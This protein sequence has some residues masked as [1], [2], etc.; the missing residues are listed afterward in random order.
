MAAIREGVPAADAL[1]RFARKNLAALAADLDRAGREGQAAVHD[2]RKRLKLLRSLLRLLRPALGDA[3]FRQ[4]DAALRRAHH[5]LAAAR[6]AGA[7][8]E[9]VHKL[10]AYARKRK[11][12]VDLSGL[13]A[14]VGAAAAGAVTEGDL[15]PSIAEAREATASLAARSDAW[16]LPRR[17]VSLFVEGMRDCYAKARRNLEKGFRGEDIE[18]LHEARKAVIHLRHHLDL[19]APLWPAMLKPWSKELQALR[20]LLG[21]ACDLDE[22]EEFARAS[23]G[24]GE[25][26]IDLIGMRRRDLLL[27]AEH[28]AGRLFAESPSAFAGRLSAIWTT[29]RDAA[30]ISRAASG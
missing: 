8:G 29:A 12:A 22:F 25:T 2:V 11:L 26:V 21:D 4:D 24:A 28:L 19:L 1:R 9:T 23:G 10:A 30:G 18:R 6:Q 20:E 17:D 13:R 3:A 5:A 16:R 7:M 27:E 15:A 14:E